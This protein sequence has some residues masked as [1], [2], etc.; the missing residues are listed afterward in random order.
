MAPNNSPASFI[1][2]IACERERVLEYN[3]CRV[4]LLYLLA[5]DK[6]TPLKVTVGDVTLCSWESAAVRSIDAVQV[7]T[8]N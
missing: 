1:Y 3:H 6:P 5:H 8:S 2:M 7:S 4:C